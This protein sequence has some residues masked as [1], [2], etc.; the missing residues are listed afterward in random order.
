MMK[1]KKLLL[2]GTPSFLIP[3]GAGFVMASSADIRAA[4][5]MGGAVI[6]ILLLTSI[7]VSAI[8]NI[9]PNRAK[10]PTYILIVTGFTSLVNMFMSAY[11]PN[12]VDMLGVHLACL[13]V[14]AV[15]FREVNEVACMEKEGTSIISALLTGAFFL[16]IMVVCALFR[17]VLGNGSFF[18]LKIEFLQ[19]YKIQTL[20]G[21][22]GGYLVLAIVLAVI[23][24]IGE[25]F[26]AQE[27]VVE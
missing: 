12:V 22:F 9:V 18:G 1:L 4:L 19:D 20:V 7:V 25:K 6:V 11:F 10:V 2:R 21:A 16:V 17:E 26:E 5:G 27:E 13:A 8:K 3:L 23:R 15:N 14:S 24:K